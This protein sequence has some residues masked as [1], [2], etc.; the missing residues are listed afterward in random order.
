MCA[1]EALDVDV[2]TCRGFGTREQ[3]LPTAHEGCGPTKAGFFGHL[4][5]VCRNSYLLTVHF[6]LYAV[7]QFWIGETK[8]R[9]PILTCC[10]LSITRASSCVHWCYTLKSRE[11]KCI[12]H[13]LHAFGA[14]LLGRR[15]TREAPIWRPTPGAVNEVSPRSPRVPER[16]CFVP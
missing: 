10:P 5:K 3:R 1:T 4:Y 14:S 6:F 12:L 15:P 16:A 9:T 2:R 11:V 7:C 13:Y 8:I